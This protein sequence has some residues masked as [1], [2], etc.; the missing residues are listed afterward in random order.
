MRVFIGIP[1]QNLYDQVQA[2]AK[3]YSDLPVRWMAKHNL[4]VTLVPPWQEYNPDQ[5]ATLL[6]K[7]HGPAFNLEFDQISFGPKPRDIRLLWATGP[8]SQ[9]LVILKNKIE[10]NLATDSEPRK[11]LSHLTLARLN[12][13]STGKITNPKFSI[14]IDWQ[15]KVSSFNFYAVSLNPEGAEYSVLKEFKL[16]N[17]AKQLP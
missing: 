4:H 1:A 3:D 10:E 9:Q 16:N 12:R 5:I 13:K 15:L 14:K 6:D 11:H 2:F 7:D 17:N 8:S